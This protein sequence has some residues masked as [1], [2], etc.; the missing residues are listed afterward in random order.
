MNFPIDTTILIY[1]LGALLIVLVA[2]IVRLEIRLG[3]LLVGKD[4]KSLEDSFVHISK[5]LKELHEFTKEMEQYLLNVEKR[6]KR[7]IQGIETVRFNPFKGTGDGGN[8]S[9]SAAFIN[10][11]GDGVILTSMYARDRISMFAKPLK[12]FV[13][14]FELTEEEKQALDTSKKNLAP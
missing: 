4:A 14:E 12:G 11:K 9:F 13:S 5:E 2:W 7:S 6:L 10:E 8:Q 3:R 1:I